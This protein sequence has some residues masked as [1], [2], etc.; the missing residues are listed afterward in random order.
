[1]H[2]CPKLYKNGIS[3]VLILFVV[4]CIVDTKLPPQLDPRF[5]R[6]QPQL[7]S[8]IVLLPAL[9][10]RID[11]K[12]KVDTQAQMCNRGK[13]KLKEKGYQ[14]SLSD[15]MGEVTQIAE[16]DLK[17]A[18]PQ[19]IKRLGPSDAR[20]VMVLVLVDVSTELTFGSTGNAEVAG[21]L[22]D[23]ETGVEVWREKGTC[24]MGQGGLAGMA[25][26]GLMGSWAIKEATNNLLLK[27]PRRSE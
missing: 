18:D 7:I 2:L 1:M 11:K 10:A 5:P 20:W 3:L 16:D 19:W 13:D 17:S 4:G 14:V 21:F 6:L 8:H 24:Q 15:N 27:F 12:E 23:K 22:F 25:M 26:K 9:D